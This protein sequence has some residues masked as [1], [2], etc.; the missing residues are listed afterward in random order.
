MIEQTGGA[1]GL[2]DPGLLEASLAQPRQ[3]FAGVDLDPN[4]SDEAACLGFSLIQNHPCADGNK[5]SGHA[6]MQTMRILNHVA[7]IADGESAETAVLNVASGR[8]EREALA[9]W[10][11]EHLRPLDLN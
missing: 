3:S 6:A 7:L 8:W 5:R 11:A 4:L 1:T 9:A 2:R 10:D